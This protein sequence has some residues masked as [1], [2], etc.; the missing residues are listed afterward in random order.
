MCFH[1]QHVQCDG[2]EAGN[3]EVWTCRCSYIQGVESH[4]IQD[5][6]SHTR[7][8]T[9]A[10]R[11]TSPGSTSLGRNCPQRGSAG[12]TPGPRQPRGR[13]TIRMA[14][15]QSFVVPSL[16]VRSGAA[17]HWTWWP[18]VKYL[19]PM[20]SVTCGNPAMC[21]AHRSCHLLRRGHASS[22]PRWFA[23]PAPGPCVL[24]PT[25]LKKHTRRGAAPVS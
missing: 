4:L 10:F 16:Q 19:P 3:P 8:L 6:A 17:C 12:P 15:G 7:E 24:L 2:A 22:S 23:R 5:L 9:T 25:V 14:R 20:G 1:F 11:R 13:D 18:R 21:P